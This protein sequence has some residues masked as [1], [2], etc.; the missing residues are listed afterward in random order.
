MII[1]V[2]YFIYHNPT[3]KKKWWKKWTFSIKAICGAPSFR[4]TINEQPM[5]SLQTET[6]LSDIIP[7]SGRPRRCGLMANTDFCLLALQLLLRLWHLIHFPNSSWVSSFAA[8]FPFTAL[9]Y[10]WAAVM[11][12]MAW[13]SHGQHRLKPNLTLQSQ[14]AS[15]ASP[16]QSLTSHMWF[17]AN[18]RT[19]WHSNTSL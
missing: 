15:S 10:V 17:P 6:R 19:H 1:T 13:F 2:F 7:L 16:S 8:G 3:I 18:T 14:L 5:K 12:P 11:E 4:D 9:I